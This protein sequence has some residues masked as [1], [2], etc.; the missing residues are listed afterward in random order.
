MRHPRHLAPFVLLTL[1]SQALGHSPGLGQGLSFQEVTTNSGLDVPM[2][3]LAPGLSVADINGDGWEDVCI[4]GAANHKPQLF[5]NRGAALAAGGG[6]PLFVD[7]TSS[8]LPLGANDASASVFADIDNDGDPDLVVARR[9][10]DPQ[11]GQTSPKSTGIEFFINQRGGREFVP[12]GAPLRLGQDPTPFGGLTVA[13]ADMD[14]DLDVFYV[15]N[16]GGNGVGGPAFFLRNDPGINFT[17]ATAVFGADLSAPTRYFSTIMF[18]FNGD[19]MPDLH[20]AVDFFTDRHFWSVAPGLFHEVTTQVGA[21]HTGADM[22]LTMGDPDMDGDFDLYSTNINVGVFYENDGSGVFTNTASSHGIGSF[23]HGLT[24]SVG[25][26]TAFVDLDNDMDEDLVTVSISSPAELFEN[27]G[28]GHFA[29]VS[30]G[31]GIVLLGRSLVPFDFD[32]DGD[33]DLLI[34]IGGAT[35]TPR[36]W[37]NV[38]PATAGNHWLVVDPRGGPSN[39]DGIGAHVEVT[40]GSTTMHRAIHVGGSFKSGLPLSAH[41]GLGS[42]QIA[43]EVKVIWPSGAVSVRTDVRADQAIRMPE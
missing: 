9:F 43:D 34:G 37:E 33:K 10:K 12:L 18:D 3:Q 16:G 21:T 36:L 5:I 31:A 20:C 4:T 23:N 38:S 25:W 22:G 17:D 19:L 41:F 8:V 42:A 26:G 6:G 30:A 40:V 39:A 24:T 32:R 7:V 15:H 1:S 13:D 14:G 35:A 11:T 27:G 28:S 2:A 29:K